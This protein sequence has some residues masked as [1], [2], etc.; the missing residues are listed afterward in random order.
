MTRTENGLGL[1][2]GEVGAGT[3][4]AG[5]QEIVIQGK[6]N[7]EGWLFDIPLTCLDL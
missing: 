2:V 1:H 4:T 3:E 5:A 7:P 6:R